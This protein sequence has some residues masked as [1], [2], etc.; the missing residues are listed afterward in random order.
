MDVD[1][2]KYGIIVGFDPSPYNH[3]TMAS[4]PPNHDGFVGSY[5]ILGMKPNNNMEFIHGI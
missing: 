5:W 2:P 3:E 4:Q 1:S